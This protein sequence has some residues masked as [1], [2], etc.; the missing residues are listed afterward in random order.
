MIE[1]WPSNDW[2]SCM[3]IQKVGVV[4]CIRI[5]KEKI[6]NNIKTIR[7]FRQTTIPHKLAIKIPQ[8]QAFTQFRNFVDSPSPLKL[9]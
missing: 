8:S 3:C 4:K 1:D 9:T 6:I 5:G 7:N 2:V